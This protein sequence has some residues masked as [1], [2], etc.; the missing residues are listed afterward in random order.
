MFSAALPPEPPSPQDPLLAEI[1][2]RLA[3]AYRPE[4]IYLFG[5]TA[6]GDAGPDSD[7]DIL[8][9]VPDDAS[10]A[11]KSPDAGY[12]AVEGLGRSG[13]FMVWTRGRFEERLRLQASLPAAV[14]REGKLLYAG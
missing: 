2:N 3:K 8:I 10:A 11:R 7:Y 14:L 12:L 5:S 13:D 9:L 6:R 4:K 1:V